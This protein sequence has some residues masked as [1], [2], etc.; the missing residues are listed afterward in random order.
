MADTDQ[1]QLSPFDELTNQINTHI[2]ELENIARELTQRQEQF[3]V[4]AIRRGYRVNPA[5][6]RSSA[7]LENAIEGLRDK[8]QSATTGLKQRVQVERELSTIQLKSA[9]EGQLRAVAEAENTRQR[10]KREEKNIQRRAIRPIAQ[11]LMTAADN[12]D[13]T[14]DSMDGL[15]EREDLKNFTDGVDLSITA[16]K[17]ALKRSGIEAFGEQ[18]VDFDPEIH[19][20]IAIVPTPGLETEKVILVQRTGYRW[21]EDLLRAAQVI[22]GKPIEES[23]KQEKSS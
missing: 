10:M 23:T 12:F 5:Q 2:D 15:R 9:Q 19:E 22:V 20:A 3:Y 4:R 16:F 8:L 21:N 11:N 13:K 18:D 1:E 17:D 14:S 7:Q 6:L